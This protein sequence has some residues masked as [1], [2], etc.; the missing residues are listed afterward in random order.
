M[1]SMGI[2]IFCRMS[3]SSLAFSEE[4]WTCEKNIE[5]NLLTVDNDGP[6]MSTKRVQTNNIHASNVASNNP[7]ALSHVV[8]PDLT[9]ALRN[10]G[11]RARKSVLEGYAL[12]PDPQYGTSSSRMKAMSTGALFQSSRDVALSARPDQLS[13]LMSPRKRHR[14]ASPIDNGTCNEDEPISLDLGEHPGRPVKPLRK[15]GRAFRQTQSL[16]VGALFQ[17]QSQSVPENKLRKMD[18]GEDDWS[19]DLAASST[20]CDPKSMV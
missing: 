6:A 5:S 19:L 10:V 16:P 9:A 17:G 1:H 2:A 11:M 7:A 8:S 14:S 13:S 3:F 12:N 18:E 15:N 20:T 4:R